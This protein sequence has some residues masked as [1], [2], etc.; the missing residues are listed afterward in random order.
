MHLA[1][2][3]GQIVGFINEKEVVPFALKKARQP[4]HRIKEIV[5][6]P[7][8]HIAP[9]TQV[10]PQLKGAYGVLSGIFLQNF[11]REGRRIQR[12]PQRILHPGKISVGVRADLRRAFPRLAQADFVL[13]G[14]RYAAQAQGGVVAPQKGEGVF[15]GGAGGSPGCEI[16]HW[17]ANA[18][19]HGL[20][21][22]EEDTHGFSDAG[23]GL[24]EQLSAAAA[25]TVHFTG[26]S[27]LPGAVLGKGEGERLQAFPALL[28]PPGGPEGPG[29]ITCQQVGHKL[30]QRFGGV[31]PCKAKGGLLVHLIIGQLY[32]HGVKPL[33]HGVDCGVNH[34]LGP[35]LGGV[36]LGD[37]TGGPG[38]GFDFIHG[39][40]SIGCG[41]NAVGPA[42]QRV[43]DGFTTEYLPQSDL[44]GVIRMF[45][46]GGAL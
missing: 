23:G 36:I 32:P 30:C 37:F 33:L 43:L 5:V 27:P 4:H 29:S 19:A 16:K 28:L 17:P 18:V 38:G 2:S 35:V 24:A 25:D 10:Q 46:E 44:G 14:Q 45:S 41:K 13:G 1:G 22:G 42:L 26:H 34:P 7:D 40:H 12:V 3:P 9:Q 31:I 15:C 6:I 21:S 39:H 20:E 8:D 11:C